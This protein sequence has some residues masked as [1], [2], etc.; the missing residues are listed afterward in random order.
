MK[1]CLVL[2]LAV[3]F[4]FGCAQPKSYFIKGK[5]VKKVVS[6]R[7]SVAELNNQKAFPWHYHGIVD[8]KPDSIILNTLKQQTN[9]LGVMI[10]AGSWCSDTHSNMP[11][12]MKVLQEM[13]VGSSQIE[14]VMLDY[15]KQ[16]EWFNAGVFN[17]TNVPT[18]IFFKNGQMV[19]KIVEQF[20]VNAE[21]DLLEI[22]K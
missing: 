13:G 12:M 9:G 11:K 5:G 21:T 18:F 3:V 19:G 20:N 2:C 17:I 1:Q 22:L 7:I 4:W 10:F 16:S 14:I 15:K 8:Y 6:G